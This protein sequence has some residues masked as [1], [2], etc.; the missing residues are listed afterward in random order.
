MPSEDE[1]TSLGRVRYDPEVN[2]EFWAAT[3]TESTFEWVNVGT[4]SLAGASD[5]IAKTAT[6]AAAL[7]LLG[8]LSI[9]F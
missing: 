7:A 3:F 8:S 5:L 1:E 6:T 2:L 9:A 4:F